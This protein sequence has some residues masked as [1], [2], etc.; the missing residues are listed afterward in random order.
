LITGRTLCI[1]LNRNTPTTN[2]MV[3]DIDSKSGNLHK[4]SEPWKLAVT[5][6]S[7]EFQKDIVHSETLFSG[8]G[9]HYIF[10]TK[11]IYNVDK[12]RERVLLALGKQDKYLVNKKGTGK[13]NFDMSPNYK[14]AMH[15]SKYSLATNGLIVQDV[16]KYGMLPDKYKIKL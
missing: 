9:L 4:L 1:H 14:G 6:I 13:I 8:S 12:M 5:L 11:K 10:Y 16:K 2:Y 15:I 7:E 3:I